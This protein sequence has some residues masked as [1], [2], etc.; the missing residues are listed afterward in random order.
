MLVKELIAVLQEMDQEAEVILFQ[1][2]PGDKF[3]DGTEIYGI[4]D[5][6]DSEEEFG[7]PVHEGFSGTAKRGDY[8]VIAG[9]ELG[10][11][12]SLEDVAP[13]TNGSIMSRHSIS[14][15]VL[16]KVV[17]VLNSRSDYS[18]RIELIEHL[19]K[20]IRKANS[21]NANRAEMFINADEH[22]FV[23]QIARELKE[24]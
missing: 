18:D 15:V 20:S 12:D 2:M 19:E 23:K 11:S 4:C 7:L 9:E 5:L 10:G 8:I 13:K 14:V 21:R 17:E 6:M 22:K 16:A 24:K 3:V 1:R